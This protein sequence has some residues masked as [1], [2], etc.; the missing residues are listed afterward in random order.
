MAH[1][2]RKPTNKFQ[3]IRL[4]LNFG[5][6]GPKAR[7]SR[8]PNRA[9]SFGMLRAHVWDI[10]IFSIFGRPIKNQNK[11]AETTTL[12]RSLEENSPWDHSQIKERRTWRSIA[13]SI[14]LYDQMAPQLCLFYVSAR[15]DFSSYLWPW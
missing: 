12:N 7:F 5:N 10:H 3:I 2:I 4:F 8:S 1:K 6:F 9:A 15:T 11:N 14:A 13:K